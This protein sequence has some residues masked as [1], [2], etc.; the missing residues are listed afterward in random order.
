MAHLVMLPILLLSVLSQVVL[1][2]WTCSV[3]EETVLVFV[4]GHSHRLLHAAVHL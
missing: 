4:G 1:P 3:G 2:L